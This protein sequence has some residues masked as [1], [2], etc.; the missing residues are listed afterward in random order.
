M[1][2]YVASPLNNGRFDLNIGVKTASDA[3]MNDDLPLLL[4]QTDEFLF[5]ID[6]TSDALFH[7]IKIAD[8]SVLFGE[9]W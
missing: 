2:R 6:I 3:S 7:V 9:G 5:D 4:E 8:N 1:R